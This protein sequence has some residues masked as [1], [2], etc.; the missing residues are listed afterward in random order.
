MRDEGGPEAQTPDNF[1]EQD[2]A[3]LGKLLVEFQ[4]SLDE[5]DAARSFELLDLVWARLAIHIRAEHLCLFP[6]LL[7]ASKQRFTG[8][9]ATP[10]L[11]E[12]REAVRGLKSDH[13]FFMRELARS[14]NALR[15]LKDSEG[16]AGPQLAE[17]RE[18]V[19]AVCARLETHNSIEEAQAYRWVTSLLTAKEQAALQTCITR[20]FEKLPPRFQALDMFPSST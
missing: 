19:K 12:L 4:S 17:V 18:S 15:A 10:S 5:K 14:V 11:S 8:V 6:A 13:D 9:D 7:E 16:G 20:E 3:A 1:L 2:H